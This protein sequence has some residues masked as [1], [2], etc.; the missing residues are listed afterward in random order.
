[1]SEEQ[2]WAANAPLLARVFDETKYL[3]ASRVGAAAG[4]AN[5]SVF[6]CQP[7][8]GVRAI[9][10]LSAGRSAGC[11]VGCQRRPLRRTSSAAQPGRVLTAVC[12][13]GVA[14]CAWILSGLINT[15]GGTSA[16]SAPCCARLRRRARGRSGARTGVR[17]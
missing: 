17:G 1:M 4:A 10:C 11:T 5:S 15:S 14:V 12:G 2:R 8:R 13:Q 9:S 6:A 16:P 3:A 7:G